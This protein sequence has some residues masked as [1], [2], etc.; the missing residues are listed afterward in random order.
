MASN[1][2]RRHPTAPGRWH[3]ASLDVVGWRW[4]SL[5][6]VGWRSM[7]PNSAVVCRCLP[8]C[9]VVGHCVLCAVVHHIVRCCAQTGIIVTHQH[10]SGDGPPPPG[11]SLPHRPRN[12]LHDGQSLKSNRTPLPSP[13]ANNVQQDETI[14]PIVV[15]R[16]SLLSAVVRRRARLCVVV[17]RCASFSA[18]V[19]HMRRCVSLSA[20]LC[21]CAP[22]RVIVWRCVA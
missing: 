3:W 12:R 8:L 10:H 14:P 20:I 21:H 22:L 5:G 16:C 19:C 11:S 13:C 2:T 18:V 7:A 9:T 6:V 15:H 1:G 4:A 17:C